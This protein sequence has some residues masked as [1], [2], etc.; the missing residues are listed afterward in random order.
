MKQEKWQCLKKQKIH[1]HVLLLIIVIKI[2]L[3]QI[4]RLHNND[5]EVSV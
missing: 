5:N 1:A 4:K 3:N 2:L